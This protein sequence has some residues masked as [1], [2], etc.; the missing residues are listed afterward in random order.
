[1]KCKR[2]HV[3]TVE[4][5]VVL[6]ESYIIQEVNQYGMEKIDYPNQDPLTEPV[7]YCT[8]CGV[9]GKSTGYRLEEKQGG[10]EQD[11][12]LIQYELIE[13]L[14]E[15][16]TE[17]TKGEIMVYGGDNAKALHVHLTDEDHISKTFYIDSD[18]SSP[19]D[20]TRK[21]CQQLDK[22]FPKYYQAVAK[23]QTVFILDKEARKRGIK[24][25]WKWLNS[26]GSIDTISAASFF[27]RFF[28]NEQLET[29]KAVLA[30]FV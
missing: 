28:N 2:C 5:A 19:E 15:T 22:P 24:V 30:V 13:I 1:M 11:S 9:Y 21:I 17:I 6:A 18:V 4:M 26:D 14:P 20:I 8:N 12:E 7:A 3:G 25:I 23:A 27:M 10:D 29:I 16:P